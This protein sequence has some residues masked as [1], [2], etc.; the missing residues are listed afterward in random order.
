MKNNLTNLLC[1]LLFLLPVLSDAHAPDQ[2]YIFFRIYE[3]SIGG[4]FAITTKDLNKVLHLDLEKGMSLEE[5]QPYLP[6]IQ[7]Y[8]RQ[9]TAFSSPLG[10]YKLRFTKT[11]LLDGAS[12]G[13]Y[14][15]SHFVLDGV[16]KIPD[17]LDV[18]NEILLDPSTPH[19]GL[20][21]VEYNWKAGIHNNESL[22]SLRFSPDDY[23]EQLDL[24]K[25]SVLKG[26]LAMIK[27]GMHHIFIGIDHILFLLALLLPAVARRR[28][29]EK[30]YAGT[31]NPP[32][33][34]WAAWV[35]DW[36]P[37]E[38]FKPAFWYVIK[39]ITFFTIAHTITLSLAALKIVVLPSR[40]VESIIALSIG[41]AALHNIYPIFKDKDWIIVFGFG[42][43]HGFGFASVLGDIGLTGEFM[44]L[45]LL[46]FNLGVEVGQMLIISLIFPALYFLRKSKYYPKILIYG[47]VLLI[48]V[49]LYWF[50]QRFF[51]VRF[52]LDNYIDKAI[53][54]L[55]GQE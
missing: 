9:K 12:L 26:F 41:L 55:L 24:A 27:S 21:V 47:S 29:R 17:V 11:T 43:F 6:Q 31:L 4:H 39:V 45:S 2:S 7:A 8:I 44:T 18:R 3:S 33:G 32:P 16:T 13:D 36:L 14:V 53:R 37:V 34:K 52:L 40:I 1:C 49:S 19:R 28:S 48:I 30:D 15:E 50:V 25:S 20:G 23:E 5:L 51:E 38:K 10:S 42:L 46:G 35:N 54:I 22:V